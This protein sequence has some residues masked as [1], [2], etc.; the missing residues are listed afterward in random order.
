MF[1]L[2][3][4]VHGYRPI[5]NAG[6]ESMIH[7]M[8]KWFVE[9]GHRV[10]VLCPSNM[11]PRKHVL[12][13]VNIYCQ[14][15]EAEITDK[16]YSSADFV[17]THLDLSAE[18]QYRCKEYGKRFLYLSHNPKSW[19]FWNV[20][21]DLVSMAIH[22]SHWLKQTLGPAVTCQSHV[23]YP[24]VFVADHETPKKD[25][26]IT[27]V[28][29][30]LNKGAEQFK[31]IAANLP[32]YKFLGVVGAYDPQKTE[33]LPQNL[34]LHPHTPDMKND[35]YARTAITLMPSLQETWGMVGIESFCSGTPVIA[36][37]TLGLMEALGDAGLYADRNKVG[38]W[39]ALIDR[40]MTD[41][42]FY[43]YQSGLAR[44]R[45]EDLEVRCRKQLKRLEQR[46]V[47]MLNV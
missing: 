3:M 29:M 39:C 15:G 28:N 35:I 12:D 9:Q 4:H 31:T 32:Q 18:V 38:V 34:T 1:N 23:L 22:N 13:G 41:Q 10:N 33:A 43:A 45:A 6:A 21:N 5:H 42:D 37:P 19:S 25:N 36:N 27:L 47:E 30:N 26:F 2:L 40:L 11:G 8:A 7:N 16:L 24:P 44:K 20:Q 17:L 14:H 46:L